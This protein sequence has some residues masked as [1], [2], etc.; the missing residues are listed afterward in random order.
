M[1]TLHRGARVFQH[2]F[3]FATTGGF[4]DKAK[5]NNFGIDGRKDDHFT[6]G[7]LNEK[8]EI[9]AFEIVGKT[10]L[11]LFIQNGSSDSRRLSSHERESGIIDGDF[12]PKTRSRLEKKLRI[13]FDFLDMM[14]KSN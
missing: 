1:S 12:K 6:I 10:K 11:S 3:K 8:S 14:L 7:S 13:R 2:G 4:K 5:G 9:S